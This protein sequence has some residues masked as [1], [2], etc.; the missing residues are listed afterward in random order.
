MAAVAVAAAATWGSRPLEV[1]IS[2]RLQAEAGQKK[3]DK[4]W[5][6]SA[7]F[8]RV[9]APAYFGTG[10]G[11]GI[12]IGIGIRTAIDGRA[13]DTGRRAKFSVVLLSWL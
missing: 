7:V 13:Q 9:Q 5:M 8:Y 12:G 3:T 11:I 6:V 2:S 4:H 10:T 1:P